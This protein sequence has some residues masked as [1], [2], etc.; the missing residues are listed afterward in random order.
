MSDAQFPSGQW[1]GFYTY[2]GYSKQYLM[3][4][5]LE[6][7]DGK[8]TGEGADGIGQFVISGK[9]ST[10]NGECSWAKQYVRRH[11]VDYRGFREAKGIWGTWSI[12]HWKGGFHIWPL[13]EGEPLKET[14]GVEEVSEPASVGNHP[15]PATSPRLRY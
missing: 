14:Q 7:N 3:D 11:S 2:H 10:A 12:G 9:Y 15:L 4:L 13:G 6:F 1:F 5:I 8:M